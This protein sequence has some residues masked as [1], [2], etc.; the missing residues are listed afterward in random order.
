MTTEPMRVRQARAQYD[1]AVRDERL[2][3]IAAAPAL[4]LRA[5]RR[6]AAFRL[7]V[8]AML[9]V[10]VVAL[11]V[12]LWGLSSDDVDTADAVHDATSAVTTMVT[13]DPADAQGYVDAIVDDSTGQQRERLATGRDAL[14]AYVSG[15]GARPDG[16]VVSAGVET[17]SDDA[18]QVLVVAQAADPTLIGGTD[19]TS[20]VTVRV[21]MTPGD[22]GWLV[23]DTEAIS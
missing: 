15:L 4:R 14:V 19:G 20:R 10:A 22:D 9:V 11:G 5:R 21:R 18:V 13:P 6:Y 23:A 2:A 7:A 16:R 17:A 1:D 12:G 3:R 8:A